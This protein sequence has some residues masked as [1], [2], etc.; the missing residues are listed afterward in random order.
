MNKL[1]HK[2]TE[3][4]LRRFEEFGTTDIS[5][6]FVI[7]DKQNAKMQETK[8]PIARKYDILTNEAT[9]EEKRNENKYSGKNHRRSNRFGYK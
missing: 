3:F 2:T 1:E 7:C 4:E 9:G 8:Q 6:Y 5:L